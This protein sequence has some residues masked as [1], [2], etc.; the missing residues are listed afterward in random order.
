MTQQTETA[1]I[2]IQAWANMGDIND[3]NIAQET[4]KAYKLE[5]NGY[6]CWVPKKGL[7]CVGEYWDKKGHTDNSLHDVYYP[8]K[9]F[10]KKMNGYQQKFFGRLG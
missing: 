10:C 7:A 5:L 4:E 2:T 1:F 9:W 6:T 3:F 8:A